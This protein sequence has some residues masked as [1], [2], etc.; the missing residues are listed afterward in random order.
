MSDITYIIKLSDDRQITIP[1][2][3]LQFYPTI[4]QKI[5][6]GRIQPEDA[7]FLE[8][9]DAHN[10]YT[11]LTT[12]YLKTGHAPNVYIG[13][14][15]AVDYLKNSKVLNKMLLTLL[16]WFETPAILNALKQQKNVVKALINQLPLTVQQQMLNLYPAGTLVPE[17]S[18]ED[19]GNIRLVSDDLDYIFIVKYEGNIIYHRGKEAKTI[20]SSYYPD[21]NRIIIT[22]NGDI[23]NV[24]DVT[25]GKSFIMLNAKRIRSL[26]VNNVAIHLST[27]ATT[28][29]RNRIKP[30]GIY[31]ITELR[32]LNSNKLIM[33]SPNAGVDNFYLSTSPRMTVV[34]GQEETDKLIYFI[35]P[36]Y[37]MKTII[38]KQILTN[39]SPDG[40]PA[41]VSKIRWV[42]SFE[43]MFKENIINILFSYSEN[44][45]ME[46][47]ILPKTIPDSQFLVGVPNLTI[48]AQK[49]NYLVRIL[50]I[51]GSI[52]VDKFITNE[53]PLMLSDRYLVT[54]V[55]SNDGQLKSHI[56]IRSLG[57]LTGNIITQIELSTNEGQVK[58]VTI[59][60][61]PQ[62]SFLLAYRIRKPDGSSVQTNIKYN[63]E[64]YYTMDQFL[65]D[66]LG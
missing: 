14:I 36:I 52:I 15:K 51:N 17:Y 57:H 2:N 8:Y 63:I 48:T 56:L 31:Q 7:V 34:V 11:I 10:L 49:N 60:P 64:G 30:P 59:I 44:I 37:G 33:T 24:K 20:Q 16:T 22:N 54:M 42:S 13:L 4:N 23:Y 38:Q 5:E 25:E 53:V 18:F 50:D 43:N 62:E 6:G 27:D 32:N 1:Q 65:D 41:Y 28:Y 66:K 12:D 26:E 61:G 9:P 45:F 55:Q 19:W 3:L 35:N 46:V 39:Q 58:L 21:E 47:V 29:S 40:Y